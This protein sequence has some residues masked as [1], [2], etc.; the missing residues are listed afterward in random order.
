MRYIYIF[1]FSNILTIAIFRSQNLDFIDFPFV[2]NAIWFSNILT[3]LIF[4][5]LSRFVI[6]T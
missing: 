4:Q 2:R 6:S 3:L 5:A 1:F